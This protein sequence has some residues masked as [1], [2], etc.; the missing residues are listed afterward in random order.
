MLG[1]PPIKIRPG[2]AHRFLL[3]SRGTITIDRMNIPLLPGDI[4]GPHPGPLPVG[5]REGDS[6]SPIPRS[7]PP[8]RTLAANRMSRALRRR[9]TNA[10]KRLWAAL[11]GRRFLGFKFVRQLPLGN[12]IVDFACRYPKLII[13]VDGGQHDWRAHRDELRTQWLE[14]HGYRVV[15]FW[16]NEVLQDLD[17]VLEHILAVLTQLKRGTAEH[18]SS[19]SPQRGE[20]R[21]EGGD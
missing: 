19:P 15:R 8:Q 16:N 3:Q 11:R 7:R 14:T 2:T 4:V 21:G 6:A 20:G 1:K 5:E 17:S 12:Y 10:E 13:E 18:P 9:M